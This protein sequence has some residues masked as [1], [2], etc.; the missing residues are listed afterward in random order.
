MARESFETYQTLLGLPGDPVEFI[1][2]YA[3]WDRVDWDR[4]GSAPRDPRPPFA[5]LADTLLGDLSPDAVDLAPGTHD[6]GDRHAL[7]FRQMMFNLGACARLLMEDFL[8]NHGRIQIAEFR[9]PADLAALPQKTLINATGYGARA[10]FDDRTVIPVRGQ[11]ARM[12][13]Q[14]DVH[15][16]L[17]YRHAAFVPRRDG[18]VFQYTGDSDYY[19]FDDA[20]TVPSRE[21]AELAVNTIAGL[22][23]PAS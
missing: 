22:Y 6:F 1:D 15:Y 9:T 12:A 10:L 7:R 2:S 13:P 20:T 5:D 16:G 11:L 17:Y 19:G 3:L 18:A 21:E 23:A 14:S 8:V 4:R